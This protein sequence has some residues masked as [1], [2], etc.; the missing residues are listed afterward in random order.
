MTRKSPEHL[1][2]KSAS[3]DHHARPLVVVLLGTCTFAFELSSVATRRAALSAA[4]PAIFASPLAAPAVGENKVAM[5]AEAAKTAW[6]P[7]KRHVSRRSNSNSPT[8]QTW[9]PKFLRSISRWSRLLR[10]H[11]VQVSSWYSVWRHLR[12]SASGMHSEGRPR[13]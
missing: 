8:Y 6:M 9:Y 7:S 3:L 13:G 5:H 10:R 1:D 11:L 2:T 12:P 4:A